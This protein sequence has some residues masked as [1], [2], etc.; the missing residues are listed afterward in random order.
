MATDIRG[1][2]IDS[3]GRPIDG[4]SVEVRLAGTGTK[5]NLYS[6]K[7][8]SVAMD[9][10]LTSEPDGAYGPAYVSNGRYD[11]IPSKT[12]YTFD[13]TD[14][15]DILVFDPTESAAVAASKVSNVPSGNIAATDVQA[16]VNE[17]DSEKASNSHT[18]A[19]GDITS[20]VGDA[21]KL[22][23][24]HASEFAPAFAGALVYKDTGFSALADNTDNLLTFNTAP[25][26]DNS[27]WSAGDGSKLVVPSGYTKVRIT[28]NFQWAAGTAA[29]NESMFAIK[30][31]KNGSQI[32]TVK[33]AA[34]DPA[35]PGVVLPGFVLTVAA[36]DYFQ[37]KEYHNTGNTADMSS[38]YSGA[39]GMELIK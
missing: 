22:D 39:F 37:V 3:L 35:R 1:T 38:G 24:K 32:L 31:F 2:L 8:K 4:A 11:I 15:T 10:P 23:N 20:T 26:N 13:L 34:K 36:D 14:L 6:D 16:A 19:G 27:I 17:L 7:N 29:A 33:A 5:A 30:L 25:Y 9:N 12:G 28:G 18:H 21:D